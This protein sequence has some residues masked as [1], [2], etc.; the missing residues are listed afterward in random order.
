MTIHVT[1][2][3]AVTCAGVGQSALMTH[4]YKLSNFEKDYQ[5][6]NND[7]RFVKHPITNFVFKEQLAKY[8][9]PDE[10]KKRVLRSGARADISVQASLLATCEAIEQAGIYDRKKVS[11]CCDANAVEAERVALVIGGNNLLPNDQQTTEPANHHFVKPSHAVEFMDT[12]LLGVLSDAFQL[13]GEGFTV[14]GA[15]ASGNLAIIQAARLIASGDADICI[16][17]GGMMRLPISVKMA[18]RNA[19]AIG[20]V[21]ND[22]GSINRPFD[23][24]HRGFV[25]GEGAGCLILESDRSI[26]LRQSNSLARLA[27]WGQ[28]LSAERFTAPDLDTEVRV[29]KQAL[30]KGDLLVKDNEFY[31][32]AHG[33]ST[34]LG[35]QVEC[36]A[37]ESVF[38]EA[39]EIHVNS[40]KSVIGHT[41]SAAGVLESIAL[42]LQIKKQLLH[43]NRNLTNPIT[44]NI[45]FNQASKK[46]SQ[47]RYGLSNS[48][49]FSG[50]HSSVLWVGE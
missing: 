8:S 26:K 42:V 12:H 28:A 36:Q 22:V 46:V 14:G 17:L 6:P 1:G 10:V 41:L 38:K 43:G 21:K 7:E 19:N 48:F 29:M 35:D 39:K 20:A 18:L 44:K 33:T 40:S 11:E 49:G 45:N 23:H 15:S 27:G 4:L 50:V 24:A 3:G 13:K 30:A 16:V 47:L 5:L 9:L 34:P 31:I 25:P 32:N 2:L 37:I